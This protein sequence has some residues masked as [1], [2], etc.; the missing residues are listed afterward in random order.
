[1]RP[2]VKSALPCGVDKY[3]SYRKYGETSTISQVSKY[4]IFRAG[5]WYEWANTKR[6]QFPSDP[7]NNWADQALSN[8]NEQFWTNSY[9]PYAEYQLHATRSLN[10]TAGTKFAYYN[11][12]TKQYADNGKTIGGLG[13]NNPN[14][15]ITNG[16]NYSAWLPSI[17][18]NYR[19]KSNWSVYG[20]V[21]TG[22]V[23]PPSSVFDFAQG[24]N[25]TPVRTLPKQQRST[26][27]QAGTVLKLKRVTFDADYYHIRFQNSYSSTLDSSGEPAY[28]LQPSSITKGFEAESNIYIGHGVSAY[29]NASVGRATYTGNLNVSCSGAAPVCT[30]ATP[31]INVVAPPGLWVANTPSDTEAEGVTY[32]RKGWDVG[33]FNKRIGTFYADNGAY[34]NQATID[35]FNQTNAY[36]NYTIRTSGRFDQT[37]LRLSFNNLFGQHNITG[38]SITGAALTQS[39][40]ANGTGYIDPFTT[41]GPTPIAGGDNISVL[42][43]RSIMLAITFGLSPKR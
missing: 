31:Q 15:F 33:M 11:I 23:V 7:L 38:D 18:A 1:M 43:G 35:P 32:Q 39:I 27:Y 41:A 6:H 5:L 34:H 12:A 30:S 20:Q 4:G 16:G 42:P 3:N 25:G 29:L 19:L 24:P 22:S 37:K 28:F 13:T 9:Q 21:A 14:S 2:L 17:D 10:I 36:L 8:F 40:K 26:T